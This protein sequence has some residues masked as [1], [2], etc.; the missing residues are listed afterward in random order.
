MSERVAV[1]S[2]SYPRSAGDAAG[3]FV[4]S[5]VKRLTRA[6]NEVHVFAPGAGEPRSHGA[7]V[8]WLA[9]AGAFGWPGALTRF[10]ERPLRV[11]GA[12]AFCVNAARALKRERCTRIEAHFLLPCAWPIAL[13]GDSRA[14]LELVGHGSDVRLF[15]AL[16]RR[17]RSRIA[18]AWL[19][20]RAQLRVTS[21]ELFDALARAAPELRPALRVEPSPLDLDGTMTRDEARAALGL[22]ARPIAVIVAR[23]V[24]EKHVDRALRA[25]ALLDEL[26]VIVVGAGPELERLRAQ[27]SGV[28]F[29]G[30]LPR[31]EALQHI[32]AADVLVSASEHEGAPS[33]VRE[34]RAL[35]VPVVA[36]AAG[37][38]ERWAETDA[39]LL[40]TRAQ[41]SE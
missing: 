25:L 4:E 9:D 18:R 37:D 16:P 27:F 1:V 41:P 26:E 14:A 40:V 29:T 39:G 5:E 6:G 24:P 35:G 34:A 10:K 21:H 38:L 32:A 15:C 17:L 2:T 19:A 28:R 22:R 11:L 20:R 13:F 8:H 23:L 30:Q 7:T 31:T 3:H 33:V 12:S 36:V